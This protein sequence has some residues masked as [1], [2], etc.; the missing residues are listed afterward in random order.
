MTQPEVQLILGEPTEAHS[1]DL[2]MFSGTASTW[3]AGDTTITVQFVNGK[4]VAKQ[5]NR[6]KK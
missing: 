2:P 1:I 6:Q 3:Q 5:F 4:V